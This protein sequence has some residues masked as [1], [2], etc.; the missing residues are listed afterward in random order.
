MLLAY[1]LALTSLV[2]VAALALSGGKVRW[3]AWAL[4]LLILGNL[5]LMASGMTHR[6]PR[7]AK[8]LWAVSITLA[9]VILVAEIRSF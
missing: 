5:T 2:L 1:G 6:R 7:A 8:L 4:P 9:M 3:T